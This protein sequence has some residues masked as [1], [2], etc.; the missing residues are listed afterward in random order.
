MEMP[1][2]GKLTMVLTMTVLSES[3]A[4]NAPTLRVPRS[5][6]SRFTHTSLNKAALDTRCRSSPTLWMADRSSV[7]G[8]EKGDIVVVSSDVSVNGMNVKGTKGRVTSVWE[9]CGEDPICCCAENSMEEASVEVQLF[10]ERPGAATATGY[11]AEEELTYIS[12]GTM[13]QNL[14]V[15]E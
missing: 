9:K 3:M 5:C 10:T 13:E 8:F 12:S 15:S 1:V 6:Q 7:I 14:E 2:T 4:F 11:F